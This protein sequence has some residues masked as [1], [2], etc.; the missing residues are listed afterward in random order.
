MVQSLQT[1]Q[2]QTVE[3]TETISAPPSPR[4]N[5]AIT[6][7]DDIIYFH[8][9]EFF[10]GAR[11]ECFDDLFTF[12][13]AKHEWKIIKASPCPAPRSGHQMISTAS[14][15]GELWLFGG[16]FASPSGLQFYHFRD[17][18]KF[19]LATKKW[20]N[21]KTQNGPSAR[22]GH[23]MILHKKRIIL[24]GGFHDNNQSFLY[25]NDVWVFSMENYSWKKIETEG[26][27][28]SGRSGVGMG[29]AG[30]DKFVV[31]G[32]YTKSSG[33]GEKN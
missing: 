14:N 19:S 15:G 6:S 9:G 7:L 29:V 8:G 5:L 12:N 16:E 21:I 30:D 1:Q 22:S 33:K 4:S 31:F 25:H 13:T 17:L 10:N 28:P 20:E 27:A 18:W 3:T 24:F 26:I 11:V 23:R 32:G 2:N